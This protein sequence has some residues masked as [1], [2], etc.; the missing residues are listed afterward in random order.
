M[1]VVTKADRQ[2]LADIL[3]DALSPREMKCLLGHIQRKTP[4]L[5]GE[6]AWEF[7][8]PD[9][10]FAI[11]VLASTSN[12][13]YVVNPDCQHPWAELFLR[14]CRKSAV[15]PLQD[16]NYTPA[17]QYVSLVSKAS[18]ADIRRACLLASQ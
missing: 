13:M 17:S 15:R 5:C 11:E 9:G 12:P 6:D 16:G 8:T 4:I 7:A 18:Q 10:R 2:Q 3:A 1:P 14:L